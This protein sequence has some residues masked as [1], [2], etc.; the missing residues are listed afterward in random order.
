MGLSKGITFAPTAAPACRS[1]Q[2]IRLAGVCFSVSAGGF[3][4]HE[5]VSQ[6]HSQPARRH[7]DQL[8]GVVPSQPIF[9]NAGQ[10]RSLSH[11]DDSQPLDKGQV[12]SAWRGCIHGALLFTYGI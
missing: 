6:A 5:R 1:S 8:F 2:E 12:V 4:D 11:A 10:A 3:W 7:S 9:R